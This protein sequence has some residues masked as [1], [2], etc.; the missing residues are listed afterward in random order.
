MTSPP[1]RDPLAD[2]RSPLAGVHSMDRALLVKI[3][4]SRAVE[5]LGLDLI[6]VRQLEPLRNSPES[7]DSRSP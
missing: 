4:V 7:G 5:A 6:E 2:Q 1:V 3:A